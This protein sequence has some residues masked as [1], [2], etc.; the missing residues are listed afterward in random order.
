MSMYDGWGKAAVRQRRS[1]ALESAAALPAHAGQTF[2]SRYEIKY[3]LE[4]E[5]LAEVQAAL[6]QHLRLDAN[7]AEGGGYFVHSIYFDTP[8]LRFLGEKFEGELTRVK[9]RIRIYRA[10]LDGPPTGVFLEFK[11]RYDRIVDKRRCL[12]D[13]AL[14][15]VFLTQSPVQPNGWSAQ[16]T[17]LGDFLYMSH[18]F[19]LIPTVSVLY[20]RT[21]YF[22]ANWPGLRITFDRLV[23]CSPSTRLKASSSDFLQAIPF[24][25]SVMEVKYNDKIPQILLRQLNALGLQQ[26]TFSK[27][28]TSM[29]RCARR[30]NDNSSLH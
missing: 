9:P 3:L 24:G 6:S 5:R 8:D 29:E 25:Q 17:V 19:R 13:R 2:T 26:R 28:A 14:A 22:G 27:Y 20:H 23:M 18:R 1:P 4:S 30:M 15:E 16:H 10:R 21:A 12:I 11:R 7:A